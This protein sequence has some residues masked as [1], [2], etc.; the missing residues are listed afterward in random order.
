MTAQKMTTCG[1]EELRDEHDV[2]P[3]SDVPLSHSPWHRAKN[4]LEDTDGPK[5]NDQ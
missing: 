1:G 4:S 5:R 2:P 3:T